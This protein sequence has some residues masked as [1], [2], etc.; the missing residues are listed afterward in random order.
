MNNIAF[1][2]IIS[3]CSKHDNESNRVYTV[4][5]VPGRNDEETLEIAWNH[6]NLD[7]RP[8]GRLVCSSSVGDIFIL[9]GQHWFTDRT[10]FRRIT[11]QQSFKIQQLTSRDTL[12]GWDWLTEHHLLD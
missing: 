1:V 4:E 6:T 11:P 10:G 8:F 5:V 2:T 7:N 3:I 12:F 9:N